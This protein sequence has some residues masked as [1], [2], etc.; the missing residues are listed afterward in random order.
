MS[1]V[2]EYDSTYHHVLKKVLRALNDRMIIGP[3]IIS[4]TILHLVEGLVTKY[5][6]TF[7]SALGYVTSKH[8]N[9]YAET[10]DPDG[11]R[12]AFFHWVSLKLRRATYK[13][14]Y[15]SVKRILGHSVRSRHTDVDYSVV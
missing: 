15:I 8:Q 14:D 6:F 13:N 10:R 3:H 9:P 12:S 11:F 7:Q 2:Y 1:R 4:H 5:N